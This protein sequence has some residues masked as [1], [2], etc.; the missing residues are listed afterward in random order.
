[1]EWLTALALDD[2]HAQHLVLQD[3]LFD[4]AAP[5]LVSY[6]H[7]VVAAV[8][9][10]GARWAAQLGDPISALAVVS[11]EVDP[12]DS[13]LMTAVDAVRARCG[14]ALPGEGAAAEQGVVR[15]VGD[16]WTLKPATFA[17]VVAA[18][19]DLAV[20]LARQIAAHD[21]SSVFDVLSVNAIRA[22]GGN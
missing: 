10:A 15:V 17:A 19:G 16:E 11:A 22:A 13:V 20:Q 8:A 14:A 1:V 18:T 3:M 4:E 5:T 9:A 6:R 12:L 2:A 7:Q 21:A